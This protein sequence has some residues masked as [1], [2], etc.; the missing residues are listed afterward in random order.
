MTA[1]LVSLALLIYNGE[2]FL[3]PA[4]ESLLGQT[5]GDFELIVT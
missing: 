1:P 3:T 4:V 2:L 5:M